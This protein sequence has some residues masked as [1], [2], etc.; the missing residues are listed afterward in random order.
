METIILSISTSLLL[1]IVTAIV[2]AIIALRR[3]WIEKVWQKKTEAYEQ[4]LIS[5][6]KAQRY[7]D[8][9]NEKDYY[10]FAISSEEEAILFERAREGH[11]DLIKCSAVYTIHLDDKINKYIEEVIP[12]INFSYLPDTYNEVQK[13]A[14]NINKCIENVRTL[15]KQ[16]LKMPDD[17]FIKFT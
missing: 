11:D 13:S 12:S 16:D 9:R 7:A 17:I 10:P 5:L 3:F 14:L 2:S 4:I 15:A 1:A 8:Y 6:F